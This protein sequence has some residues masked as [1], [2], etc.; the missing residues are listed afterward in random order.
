[1]QILLSNNCYVMENKEYNISNRDILVKF[2]DINNRCGLASLNQCF[3]ILNP[4]NNQFLKQFAQEYY[5]ISQDPNRKDKIFDPK[6]IIE[7]ILHKVQF[8][9]KLDNVDI[10]SKTFFIDDCNKFLT[11]ND[12]ADVAERY[13]RLFNM[14]SITQYSM[15]NINAF[16]EIKNCDTINSSIDYITLI[17]DGFDIGNSTCY[18][19]LN[20]IVNNSDITD[21]ALYKQIQSHTI[22]HFN[23]NIFDLSALILLVV[24]QD[25]QPKKSSVSHFVSAKKLSNNKWRFID[26]SHNDQD[27]IYNNFNDLMNTYVIFPNTNVKLNRRLM[28]KLM[29]Y[30]K[31]IQNNNIGNTNNNFNTIN[32]INLKNN[33]CHNIN[34]PNILLN[35]NNSLNNSNMNNTS[36][37]TNTINQINILQTKSNNI[38][39]TINHTSPINVVSDNISNGHS[40]NASKTNTINKNIITKITT[41]DNNKKKLIMN[42]NSLQTNDK[43]SPN[44]NTIPSNI[45][46][47]KDDLQNEI[48]SITKQIDDNKEIIMQIA[49]KYNAE[50]IAIDNFIQN[51]CND[52]KRIF[53]TILICDFKNKKDDIY[54]YFA[55]YNYGWLYENA[56]EIISSVLNAQ[57]KLEILQIK[58]FQLDI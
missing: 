29:F 1:M 30:T 51:I 5:N 48:N 34:K 46:N 10:K 2:N 20:V 6:Y 40:N 31:V 12:G 7:P 44:A 25:G 55:N 58:L 14:L 18:Y 57:Q 50:K 35:N 9:N 24:D 41:V 47:N 16:S 28:P 23:N 15:N 54:E 52:N 33:N 27:A 8:N 4:G 22:L 19:T 32:Q 45:I 49:D 37:N 43:K 36:A 56:L 53:D 13:Q 26:S 42:N 17:K 39:N 11:G 21:I 3:S 38:T